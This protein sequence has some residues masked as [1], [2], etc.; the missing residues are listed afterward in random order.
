MQVD[1]QLANRLRVAPAIKPATPKV[2]PERHKSSVK[3]L[4]A[5]ASYKQKFGYY[6]RQIVK[7][8]QL[9]QVSG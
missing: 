3:R 5:R 6:L 9:D 4:A 7:T 8:G 1:F 2:R